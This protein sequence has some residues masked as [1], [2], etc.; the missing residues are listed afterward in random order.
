MYLVMVSHIRQFQ[1]VIYL[2]L[3]IFRHI[4]DIIIDR[5]YN[6]YILCCCFGKKVL[7]EIYTG[8]PI[9]FHSMRCIMKSIVCFT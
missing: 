4:P 6:I 2:N 7:H 1:V 9:N 5:I 3:F 8:S